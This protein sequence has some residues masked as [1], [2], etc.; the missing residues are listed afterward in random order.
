MKNLITERNIKTKY[1]QECRKAIICKNVLSNMLLT[2]ISQSECLK[3][4]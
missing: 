3:Y 4:L 2:I 1:E